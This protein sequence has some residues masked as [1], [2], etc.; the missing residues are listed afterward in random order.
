MNKFWSFPWKSKLLQKQYKFTA[1]H[2]YFLLVYV[3]ITR[4]IKLFP[5][6]AKGTSRFINEKL[7]LF[8]I[9]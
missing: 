2:H 4:K 9:E 7:T 1:N 6:K 8:Y 5:L 3:L